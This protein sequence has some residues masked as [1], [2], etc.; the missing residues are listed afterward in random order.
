MVVVAHRQQRSGYGLGVHAR[1]DPDAVRLRRAGP[2]GWTVNAPELRGHHVVGVLLPEPDRAAEPKPIL[3]PKLLFE[4]R[5]VVRRAAPE[6]ADPEW[7]P[8]RVGISDRVRVPLTRAEDGRI[9]HPE[10][11]I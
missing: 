6:L 2:E 5:V 4:A 9:R 8:E 3:L 10:Q 11:R 1:G 7:Q